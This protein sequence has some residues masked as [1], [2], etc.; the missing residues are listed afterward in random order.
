[1]CLHMCMR[2]VYMC[3]HMPNVHLCVY[4]CVRV[5]M[6]VS[7]QAHVQGSQSWV[8]HMKLKFFA[9]LACGSLLRPG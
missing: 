1:M 2:G 6:R 5:C 4:M 7:E 3:V 9:H 8:D